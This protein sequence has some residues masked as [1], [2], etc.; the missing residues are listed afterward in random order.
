ML[1]IAADVAHYHELERAV[2]A[3][4]EAFGTIDVLVN[5][6]AIDVAGPLATLPP[7]EWRRVIDVNLHG[8]FN[9]THLVYQHMRNRKSGCIMT[10]SSVLGRRGVENA[11]AYCSSKAAL[12]GFN[13]ALLSEAR[14]HNIRCTL[15]VPGGIDTGWHKQR[16]PEFMQPLEIAKLL[17][18][19][20][21]NKQ[22]YV[23]ELLL[24]P[25]DEQM[26]P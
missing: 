22:L 15:V 2:N 25:R 20:A 7:E 8:V 24:T 6:A 13:Q 3:A 26:Y 9:A 1:S 19:V 4:I 12:N 16:H 18:D 21:D 5:N 10:V 11:I 14:Q 23:P 17:L